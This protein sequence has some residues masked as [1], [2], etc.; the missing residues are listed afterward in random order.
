MTATKIESDAIDA[1]RADGGLIRIRS[2]TADDAGGVRELHAPDSDRSLYLR[3]F[4]VSR[5]T[6]VA[7]AA[8][9]EHLARTVR[10]AGHG[11]AQSRDGGAFG[12][13]PP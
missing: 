11:T 13:Y 1:V 9:T 8:G 2:I 3:F 7:T 12:P 10:P 5:V 6:A 4:S